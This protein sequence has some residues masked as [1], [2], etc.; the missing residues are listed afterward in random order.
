LDQ[1]HRATGY[2]P[3]LLALLGEDLLVDGHEPTPYYV[4][5]LA[6]YRLDNL[7]NAQK[8][9]GRYRPARWHLLT[10][11]RH[12]ALGN[13][14]LA[15]LTSTRIVRQMENIESLLNDTDGLNALFEEAV[16]VVETSLGASLDRDSLRNEASTERLREALAAGGHPSP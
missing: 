14:D 15:P 1:P 13:D 4:S 3:H 2:V 11:A 16:A 8:I 5:A 10:A 12:I 9:D 7:Y 6:H